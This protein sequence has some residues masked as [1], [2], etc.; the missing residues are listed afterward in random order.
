MKAAVYHDIG[1]IRYEDVD[2]P[3]IGPKEVLVRLGVCGLCGT[4]IHKILHKSVQTP[5]VLGHEVAGE[6]VE[7][8]S[9]VEGFAA[10]DRVFVAHHV[11][12][13]T[14]RHCLRGHHTLCTQFRATNL[15]PGGFA[16]YIRVSERHVR[17]TLLKIPDSMTY[18]Q[19]AMAEPLATV[20]H[21]AK[22][23]RVMHADRVLVMGAGQIGVIWAQLLRNMGADL[24]I[25]SDVSAFKL[26]QA[27]RFGADVT[28]NVND[29]NLVEAVQ[30]ATGG[31][32][33]DVVVIA[34]GV[35][36]LL[37][38]A[39]RCCAPGGQIMVFAGFDGSPQVS[40][41]AS[42]FFNSEISIVGSYSS[43]PT[44][45]APSLAMIAKGQIRVDDM[46]TH[47][48]PLSRLQEAV[49]VATDPAARSL[50]VI[51]TS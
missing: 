20:V 3:Q 8:G 1:A 32:G 31:A 36:S 21:G 28:V 11:P 4:D 6:I 2:T 30:A 44:E 9:G 38:D 15:D 41:D 43:M 49:N 18:A 37:A 5:V 16:E 12:C 25:V 51:L 13:F 7:V 29:E 47:R 46:I 35:S 33:V 40:I 50:K 34:V 48:F 39:V 24:V 10:G 22:L 14:C 17:A 27:R 19:A 23:L 42:R 45:Y 26:E